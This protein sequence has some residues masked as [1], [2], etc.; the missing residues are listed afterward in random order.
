MSA[1]PIEILTVEDNLAMRCSFDAA[2]HMDILPL[3]TITWLGL[4]LAVTF[5]LCTPTFAQNISTIVGTGVGGFSGDGG[6]ATAAQISAAYGVFV[7]AAGNLYVADRTNQ[8]IRK[9]DTGGTIT[10]VAGTG[11]GGFS[12]DGGAATAA[13]IRD[14]QDVCVDAA[15]NLYIADTTNNRVRKVDTG[16]TITTVAGTGVGGFS[17][18][19][20]AATA[21]Q[22]NLP[23]DVFVDAAG[24]LFIADRINNRVRKVDTGGTITTVVGTGVAGFSGDGGAATAA[25]MNNPYSVSA[26]ASGNLFIADLSNE[27]IRK[28]DSGGTITTFAGTGVAGFSGDGGAASAAQVNGPRDAMV[29]AAGN[30]FISDVNNQR[31]RKVNTPITETT[32]AAGL[33]GA[34]TVASGGRVQVFSIG[35]TGDGVASVNDVAITISDLSAATGLVAGDFTE[36]R[37]YRSTDAVLDGGDTQIGT[38]ATVNIGSS[39]TVSATT[40]DVPAAAT[41]RFYLL[42]VVTSS[43]AG[44]ALKLGFAAGGVKTSVGILGTAVAAADAD[45]VTIS[46]LTENTAAA[47]LSGA[48]AVASGGEVQVFS[49]GIDGDGLAS[50]NNVA[51]TISDLSAATGLVAADFTELRL[52]RSAD[53]VLG[54]DTQIGTQAT[55]TIGTP[56]TVSATTPDVPPNATES[57]YLISAVISS[58]VGHAFKVGF[59]AG[60][61]TTSAGALG[62]A[63]AAADAN[64]LTIGPAAP[65]LVDFVGLSQ[66]PFTPTLDWSDMAGAAT[67]TLEYAN[68]AGFTGSTLETGIAVS[69]FTFSTGLAQETFFWRARGVGAGGEQG[70]FSTSD[71]FNIIPTFTEWVMILL[72]LVM[73]AYVLF[74]LR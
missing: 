51:V 66:P 20:G 60:G 37:L 38:Q 7:D 31:I 6:A 73:A 8:R 71:S 2:G 24:N 23:R 1:K 70:A 74:R 58:T 56:T 17:G 43:T 32:A 63:V 16:G 40:P 48:S 30:L 27:R 46:F 36:I 22:M 19:G 15:G 64:K 12:G 49:I 13:Q 35:I 41:E 10:T 67:Y 45:K 5:G 55:V 21:A 62:T 34:S 72:A 14:P 33:S 25:Q 4:L 26:N 52:Y 39:T 59:A 57:F 18:D 3:R 53:A 68:N 54:G 47:G 69:Q 44:H 65:T 28:V 42:T 50:V 9:V 61:V 11:V 29:D